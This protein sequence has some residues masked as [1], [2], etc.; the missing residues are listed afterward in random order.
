M[1]SNLCDNLGVRK[2]WDFQYFIN[3][4]SDYWKHLC[5]S[6][7]LYQV[8]SHNLAPFS[9]EDRTYCY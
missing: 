7:M 3:G 8:F 9:P 1:L 6:I 2:D 5:H 4:S